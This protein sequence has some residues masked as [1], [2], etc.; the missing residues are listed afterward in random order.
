[1]PLAHWCFLIH[2]LI[3]PMTHTSPSKSKTS[4]CHSCRTHIC[5]G[6]LLP[7][8]HPL[9]CTVAHIARIWTMQAQHVSL[10]CEFTQYRVLYLDCKCRQQGRFLGSARTIVP[11]K[12]LSRIK[13]H[14]MICY[15]SKLGSN[16]EKLNK[17]KALEVF[18]YFGKYDDSAD[19]LFCI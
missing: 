7:F 16:K 5:Y 13:L 11:P 10:D 18:C 2:P 15:Q 6:D 17:Y 19:N 8:F 3:L 14:S 12:Y 4:L 9:V 1:M